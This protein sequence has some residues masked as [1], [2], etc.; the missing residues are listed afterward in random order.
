MP[1]LYAHHTFGTD[2]Y[3]KLPEDIKETIRTY[4][5]AFQA[6]LQGPDIL[7]FYRP[8]F[9]CRTNQLGHA[10]HG[11]P[12]QLFLEQVRPAIR[13][14]GKKSRE[15]A[16]LLGFICHFLLDSES[17]TYIY[18]KIKQPGYN[19]LVMEIEFDRHLLKKHGKKPLSYPLWKYIHWDSETL[20]A[21]HGIY[22]VFDIKKRELKK[23]LKSMSF[24]KWFFTTGRTLRRLLIRFG[25]LISCRYRQWEGMMM[26][27]VPKVTSPLT[28]HVLEDI[29][30]A[31]IDPC[32]ELIK[33]FD[34]Y[35]TT[36]SPLHKRF[37][38]TFKSN[39]A[40]R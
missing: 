35:V 27:L 26:D 18:E 34:L 12:F 39:R 21:I 36:D 29:Y 37:H 3:R 13:K 20:Q 6:G 38:T 24:V 32:V 16:Y 25:M 2:V 23:A 40:L 28:N 19:H 22:Q 1:S 30:E 15:Y 11:Q 7:F 33:D 4:P 8:F 17:H 9:K 31:S 14:K 5:K 10:Q